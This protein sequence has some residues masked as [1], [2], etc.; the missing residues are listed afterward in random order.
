[1]GVLSR[2]PIQESWMGVLARSKTPGQESWTGVL[3][4]SLNSYSTY[5]P[6][7]Q[8]IGGGEAPLRGFGG[9]APP[10]ILAPKWWLLRV[11]IDPPP[12]GGKSMVRGRWRLLII[13]YSGPHSEYWPPWSLAPPPVPTPVKAKNIY[14][15][16][17]FLLQRKR[18][19]TT[20]ESNKV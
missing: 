19:S 15:V 8:D 11:S 9:H 1:M 13:K 7:Y 20:R 17:T 6:S 14:F 10:R 12:S 5:A 18:F 3:D 2:S 4:R 16:L